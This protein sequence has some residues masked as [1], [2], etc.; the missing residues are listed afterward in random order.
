MLIARICWLHL[1]S[2]RCVPGIGGVNRLLIE[3]DSSASVVV[4]EESIIILLKQMIDSVGAFCMP[5]WLVSVP[6]WG[7]RCIEVFCST[8]L[9][10]LEKAMLH[11]QERSGIEARLVVHTDNHRRIRDGATEIEIEERN[12]P[13]GAR[14]FDSL[15]EA[16]RDVMRMACR[17][18]RVALLT[19]DLLVS[20]DGL[21]LCEEI[22]SPDGKN[23]VMC[24]GIRAKQEGRL[25]ATDSA[26][27]M[28]KWAWENAHPITQSSTYP[29]GKTTDLSRLYFE[30]DGNVVARLAMPHPIAVKIDG[31]NLPFSP[32]ID[33]SLMQ[34]FCAAD[35]HLVTMTD[36]LA[37]VELSPVDKDFQETEHSIKIRLDHGGVVMKDPAQRWLASHRVSLLGNKSNIT[38]DDEVMKEVLAYD[39]ESASSRWG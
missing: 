31:R 36:R 21:Q 2:L 17:N 24:C 19:A 29:K 38:I 20:K 22:L 14:D 37:L 18:D 5:R 32:T 12:V 10:A 7:E 26:Q 13:A 9:P 27:V 30:E 28:M 23:L 16:H 33:A 3:L 25:P 35:T 34:N 1:G 4:L 11:L 6:V 39:P 15:S 8:A